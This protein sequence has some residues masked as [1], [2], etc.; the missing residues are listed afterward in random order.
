MPLSSMG[1]RAIVRD[2]ALSLIKNNE[3][4]HSPL[5]IRFQ[6]VPIKVCILWTRHWRRNMQHII[7]IPSLKG[8]VPRPLFSVIRDVDEQ[9]LAFPFGV[10]GEELITVDVFAD[11]AN[12]TVSLLFL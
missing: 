5:N 11:A 1:L 12:D 7:Q 4:T 2:T 9:N 10:Y 6:E 3:I 8:F